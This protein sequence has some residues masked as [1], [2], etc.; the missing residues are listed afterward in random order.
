MFTFPARK[1][2]RPFLD[3]KVFG[4]GAD[5]STDSRHVASEEGLDWLRHR[6]SFVGLTM[7]S[8]NVLSNL[9][10]RKPMVYFSGPCGNDQIRD[11]LWNE[12]AAGGVMA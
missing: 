3:L 4:H 7:N 10:K 9:V 5:L 6:Y 8:P 2:E 12:P 1:V 11:R